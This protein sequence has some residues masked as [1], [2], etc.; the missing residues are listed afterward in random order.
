MALLQECPGCKSKL[1]FWHQVEVKEGDQTKKIEKERAE[2]PQCGFKLRKAC[3]KVYW[4]EFY[5]NGRRKRER[6]GPSKKAAEQRLR[7]VLKDR[8]EERF[9]DKD[10]AARLTLGELC[11]WYLDLPEVKAKD[12]YDRDGHFIG[13]LKRLLGEGIKIKDITPGKMEGYQKQRLACYHRLRMDPPPTEIR[14]PLIGV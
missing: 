6:I 9:I 12:S 3:G 4:I 10:P 11:K 14:T 7:D 2:C 1:S 8:T 13:H 5:V